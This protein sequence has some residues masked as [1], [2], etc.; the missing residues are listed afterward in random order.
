MEIVSI[1]EVQVSPIIIITIIIVTIIII[2][3]IN[4]FILDMQYNSVSCW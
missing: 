2:I 3:I 4:Q 1:Y